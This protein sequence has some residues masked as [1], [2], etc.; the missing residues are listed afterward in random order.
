MKKS[1]DLDM[2][3]IRVIQT[4]IPYLI[5]AHRKLGK[6]KSD[7]ALSFWMKSK[8]LEVSIDRLKKLIERTIPIYDNR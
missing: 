2:Q 5:S 4:A 7:D 6:K 1:I 8:S 3:K